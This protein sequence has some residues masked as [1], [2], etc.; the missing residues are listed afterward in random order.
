M[1]QEKLIMSKKKERQFTIKQ[2]I[3]E[4]TI[5]NQAN[6]LK[7][8]KTKGFRTT[9]ATLSRDL[10]EM[11]IVR[12]PAADGYR[13][14][15]AEHEGSHFFNK[16]IGM[17]ILGVYNNES[18][19]IVRT[20]TGRAKGVAIFI[21]QLKHKNVMATIAGENTILVIPDSVKNIAKIKK[22]LE[23]IAYK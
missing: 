11:G 21:D 9:Q 15:I 17:E 6:L 18:N 2:I 22:D 23:T 13:Y 19:L 3:Q 20:M 10:H 7:H 4:N 12:A 16:I 8:L 5:E 14:V 1:L